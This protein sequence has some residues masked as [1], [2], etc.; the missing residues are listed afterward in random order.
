MITI[1]P[2]RTG[3]A[4]L[5]ALTA[6]WRALRAAADRLQRRWQRRRDRLATQRALDALNPQLLRD[7]GIDRSEIPSFA[8]AAGGPGDPTRVRTTHLARRLTALL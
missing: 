6:P 8:A 5:D 7:L 2:P 4:P 1:T 3:L